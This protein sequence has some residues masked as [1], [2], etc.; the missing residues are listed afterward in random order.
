VISVWPVL[1]KLK[2]A[3]AA[4]DGVATCKIGLEQGIA[5]EDYPI[6]RLV[7]T[8]MREGGNFTRRK[9]TVLIYFGA[10]VDESKDGLEGVYQTLLALEE[11]I[12]AAATAPGP[13]WRSKYL[14]T[15]TDEDR[16]EL[17][18]LMAVRVEVEG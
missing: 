14:D 11:K 17:Y 2:T 18:K 13:G 6:I 9:A 8:E 1:E 12:I 10:A 7:P 3:L 5:H 4:V 15:I 16:L